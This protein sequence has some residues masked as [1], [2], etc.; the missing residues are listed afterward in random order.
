MRLGID[1]RSLTDRYYSGISEYVANILPEMIAQARPEEDFSLFYNCFGRAGRERLDWLKGEKVSLINPGIPNKVFNYPLE[2]LLGRPKLDSLVESDAFWLPHF[3]FASF[4]KDFPYILTIHDLSFRRYPEFFNTRKN[5]WH[6]LLPVRQLAGRASKIVAVSE[7]TKRDIIELLDIPEE[8]IAVVY[9]GLAGRVEVGERERI[10]IAADLGLN[11][12]YVL[13]LGT[14]EP[15]K[16]VDGLIAAFNL[17]K[18]QGHVSPDFRLII[19]GAW[20]WKAGGIREAWQKSP[21]RSDISFL[22]YVSRLEKEVLYQYASVFAYPSFYE[23]F[24]FPPLEAMARSCPVVVGNSSSL[25]EICGQAAL[26]CPPGDVMSLAVGLEKAIADK[27]ERSR[28]I[29][30]GHQQVQRYSWHRAAAQYLNLLRSI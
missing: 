26:Y 25:P 9:S 12:P 21:F 13:Y 15:R 5:L 11:K 17:L 20:G 7:H 1:I 2:R 18:Q 27:E 23:G 10:G 19:A 4:S 16:N 24:G 28:L 30:A 6:R 14:V 29:E 3:N 22:G 8:K